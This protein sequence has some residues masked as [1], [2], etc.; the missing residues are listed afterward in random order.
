MLDGLGRGGVG[1]RSGPYGCAAW[2]GEGFE[3]AGFVVSRVIAY[4]QTATGT[5]RP[6]D[7][8]A[9]GE[10]AEVPGIID[11]DVDEH[12]VGQNRLVEEGEE[13]VFAGFDRCDIAR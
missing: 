8:D 2:E 3:A 10:D 7:V 4:A 9:A 5:Q 1:P 11:G 13:A 12:V 6:G